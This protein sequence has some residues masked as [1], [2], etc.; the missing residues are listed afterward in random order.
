[1]KDSD[2]PHAKVLTHPTAGATAYGNQAAYNVHHFSPQ[3]AQHMERQTEK[4][5]RVPAPKSGK[6]SGPAHSKTNGS[7]SRTASINTDLDN[8]NPPEDKFLSSTDGV[9]KEV[10]QQEV[11]DESNNESQQKGR[12][13]KVAST[14]DKGAEDVGRGDEGYRG[15]Q[16]VKPPGAAGASRT[17]GT[18]ERRNNFKKST[19][20]IAQNYKTEICRSHRQT[21]YCEYDSSCQFAH[22]I[23]ELRP[24]HYGLKY[25]TQECKNYHAEG[26]CRF[27]SRCKFIHDEHRIRVAPDEF[28][29][30][31]PSENLVRVEV[32]ENK[33][34]Q[35][36]LSKLVSTQNAQDSVTPL[37]KNEVVKPA[38]EAYMAYHPPSPLP[39]MPYSP[40]ASPYNP[41]MPY[42]PPAAAGM[43][44]GG[45]AMGHPG[46][47]QPPYVLQPPHSYPYGSPGGSPY[48][49]AP[50]YAPEGA[51][52]VIG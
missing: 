35:A 45:N 22:G 12:K 11:N 48:P 49:P 40:D 50:A 44:Y 28:W 34:R 20:F 29:L 52:H 36:E 17:M 4:L 25:K 38:E 7:S 26:Y 51:I 6:G 33:M 32:V 15:G 42:S 14:K 47:P 21:G 43:V 8:N 5:A 37:S 10:E 30:V 18:R 23:H 27:G 9:K 31:S 46:Y 19:S 2:R 41:Y 3:G 16:M 39:Y 24:R 13:S 1:M